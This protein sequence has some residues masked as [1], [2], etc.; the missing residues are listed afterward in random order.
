MCMSGES[1]NYDHTHR[2]MHRGGAR[3]FGGS[4]HVARSRTLCKCELEE[5]ES[6]CMSE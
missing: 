4:T 2:V 3:L 5:E 1:R 6:E